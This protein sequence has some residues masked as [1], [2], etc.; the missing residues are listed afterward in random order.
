MGRR[1]KPL[2]AKAE[3]K[4][5]LARKSP[6]DRGAKVRELEKRLVEALQREAEASKREAEAQE[7]QKATAE[8]LRII[9][10]SP[11]DMRP[12][13]DAVAENAARV[14][15]AADALIFQ[16][17]GDE[18]RQVAHFG[19]LEVTTPPVRQV[20]RTTPSGRAILERR[21]IHIDDIVPLL[22]SEYPG[23]KSAAL[24]VGARTHLAAPLMREGA[25]IGAILIRRTVRQPFTQRQI[26]LLQTFADQAVIA[27]ENVRLFTELQE[28][29]QALTTAHAQVSEA[30]DQQ[31]AT[32]EILRVISSSPTDVQPVFDAVAESAARLC[33]SFDVSIYRR[34]GDRLLLVAH[35]GPILVGRVGEFSLP[36]VR[37]TAAGRTVLDGHTV[38]V[39]DMQAEADEFPESS[40][41]ARR[42]GFRTILSVP[43]MREGVAIGVM[44]PRRTDARLFTDRQVA[45]LQTFADQAV[46][47]IENVRLFTELQTSNRD[48][49]TALDT[50]TATSDILRVISRSQT[51]V[52]PVFD[53][54]LASAVRLLQGY[55]GVV[56]RVAGD[57]LDLAALTRTT[58]AGD[59]AVRALY[60]ERLDSQATQSGP[61]GIE[62]HSISP[63]PTAIPGC[64]KSSTPALVSVATEAT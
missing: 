26:E 52:Q 31:T 51:D 40:E 25:S 37:G 58:D 60:P 46:I 16:L 36:L 48:L 28:K 43:L 13:M 62:H 29:N 49:T 41:N 24:A 30:L 8:I 14:C 12:V 7:Q 44:T 57:Q 54:I 27:I 42:M 19:S 56:T 2:K 34:D 63:T 3:A 15:G 9:R 59:A 50:Q 21:T 17:D 38:H 45:L 1:A 39:T 4:R 6:K 32:S 33:D 47:A 5:P 23:V 61:P 35:H 10:Q 55:S 20:S 22:E 18:Q 11:T 53:A 64:P